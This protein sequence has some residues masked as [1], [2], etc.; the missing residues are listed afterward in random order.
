MADGVSYHAGMASGTRVICGEVS[1]WQELLDGT[2][3]LVLE[4]GASGLL[5]TAAFAWRLAG[6]G[7]ADLLE[8]DLTLEDRSNTGGTRELYALLQSGTCSIDPETGDVRIEGAYLVDGVVGDWV[9]LGAAG[10]ESGR[11]PCRFEVAAAEW[12]GELNVA[13]FD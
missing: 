13:E 5:L 11:L 8:G 6:E 3:Q 7:E 1:E 2:V 9:T 4:G 10:R 12:R